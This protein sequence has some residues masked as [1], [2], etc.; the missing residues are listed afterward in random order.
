MRLVELSVTNFRSLGD[1]Q[2]IPIRKQTILT[3]HNDCG[4]TAALD[5]IAFLLGERSVVDS[6]ISDFAV[7][8]PARA[9]LPSDEVEERRT[10]I[11]EGRFALSPTEEKA[12]DAG[13]TLRMRRRHVE[14]EGSCLEWR[15][16]V[17]QN[18]T[19]RNIPALKV[20]ELRALASE[21]DISLREDQSNVKASW[22]EVLEEHAAGTEMV[23]DWVVAPESVAAA[24]PQ[25]LYFKGDAAELPEAVVRSILTA[26]LREYT[27]RE[28]T[29]QKITDLEEEFSSLLKDDVVRLQKL[30]EE[31]CTLDTFTVDPSVQFRPTV[32]SLSLTAAAPGQRAVSFTAAG[33]G[34]SRRVSLALWEASQELLSEETEDGVGGV[35]IA[36]DEPDT[37]LD[38]DHQRRIMEMIKASASAAQ[39]TVIV[40]THS[41][42]LIDGVDI[43]DIVHLNSRDGR[44]YVQSLGTEDDDDETRR[45][46]SNMAVSLGFRNSVLLH[47]RCFVGVEGP[48]EYAALPTLFKLAFGYPIQSAGIALWDCGG[49]DGALS[50]AKFLKKH[51]RTVMF[52]VDADTMRDKQKRFN[53]DRLSKQG[54]TEADCLF[55]GDPNE[56]EDVF[57]DDQWADTMNAAWPR[58]D[59]QQWTAQDVSGLRVGGKFSK[60]LHN[61]L[62]QSS[63]SAPSGKEDMV[64][65]LTRRL[66]KPSDVPPALVKSFEDA[67]KVACEAGVAYWPEGS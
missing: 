7:G 21:L 34:R 22:V 2:G 67:I 46:L 64:V 33:S 5:A 32:H 50:F 63:S 3:G 8:E 35:I 19:L 14:D 13:P 53:I 27:L 38:Y 28:E 1:V 9:A 24:L 65:E 10:V 43:Q 54:F 12:L 47:E 26:K 31:R 11:V 39:S 56:L 49:N 52:L 29:R 17:P 4:K 60:S 15:T 25:L 37:H 30:I 45:F 59:A 20:A 40:A 42:N 44:A 57:S 61:T 23:T 18:P 36:Y 58:D 62:R 51:R 48:T 66:R 55:L 41:L 16:A 6:D